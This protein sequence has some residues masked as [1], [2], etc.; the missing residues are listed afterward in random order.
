[1][2]EISTAQ[3][4]DKGEPASA[5]VAIAV[6]EHVLFFCKHHAREVVLNLEAKGTVYTI[7][8]GDLEYA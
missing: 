4:C 2:S 5:A 6:G 8:E 1:M 3:L 7:A